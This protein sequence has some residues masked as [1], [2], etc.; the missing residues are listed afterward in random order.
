MADRR[1]S[2]EG[3]RRDAGPR[4]LPGVGQGTSGLPPGIAP[5]RNL[6]L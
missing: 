4:T 5:C 2:G 1:N 3:R 6:N